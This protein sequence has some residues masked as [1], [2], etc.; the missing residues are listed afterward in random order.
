MDRR[1]LIAYAL[2]AL[3]LLALLTQASGSTGW[4]WLG[5]V[6]AASLTAYVNTRTYGFLL[7]GAVL[8]GSALGIVLTDLFAWDGAFLVSLGL[9]L[10]AVDRVEPRPQRY[11]TYLGGVLAAL[12]LLAGVVESG[13]LGTL[14]LPLVLIALGVALLWRRRD[15]GGAFPPPQ[16]SVHVGPDDMRH[17]VPRVTPEQAAPATE[18]ARQ[19]RTAADATNDDDAARE[20]ARHSRPRRRG[21][22]G[23][24]R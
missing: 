23:S 22:G 21:A 2:I 10:V 16:R 19:A 12:G 15:S 6:A 8:A 7:L 17:D 5:V 3:G 9:G 1:D 18:R 13:V 4:L 11:A 14:W 20:T 24:R